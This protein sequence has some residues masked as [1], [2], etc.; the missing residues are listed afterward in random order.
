[1]RSHTRDLSRDR[2]FQGDVFVVLPRQKPRR[3]ENLACKGEA[4][5][6]TAR[7]SSARGGISRETAE[8]R[9]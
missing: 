2:L 4:L 6:A 3:F 5:A 9:V 1:M 7:E 8:N